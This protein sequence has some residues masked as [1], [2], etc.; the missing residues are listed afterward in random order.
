MSSSTMSKPILAINGG[1]KAFPGPRGRMQPKIGPEEFLSVAERFG[2]PPEAIEKIRAV[3][4][5]VDWGRGPT[6]SRYA[7]AHPRPSKGEVLE[8]AA[9][10]IFG[11]RYVLPVSSGTGALHSAFVAV[12]VGP[13]AEVIV[14]A[15]GFFATAS[16]VVMAR[17]VPV[18]CDVD[19]SLHI[20]PAK[21]EEKITPRTV[22]IAPTCVMGGV[23]DLE[24]ILQIARRHGLKVVEDCA[25]SPGAKYKGRY[26]GAWGDIGCFSI[27]AYKVV[28]GGEGGLVVTNDQRLYERA[29]QL[30]EAGGLWRPD[31]FAPPRYPG[32]LFCGTNYRMSELEAAV[33]VIQLRKMPGLVERYNW[34]QRMILG[35]LKTYREVQPVR[36]NDPEG[37]VG[38]NIRFFTSS[39]ELGRKI[40]A[41]LNAEGIGCG[42]FLWPAECAI[43]GPDAPPDWH[44]YRYMFPLILQGA[45]TETLCPFEC[46]VY[47]ERGGQINYRP[48]D[49][50]TAADLFDRNIMIW[51]ESWYNDED[52]QA[53]AAGI[54]KVLDAY[55][56][57][58]PSA[59]GW[60]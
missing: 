37:G 60:V 8:Q 18:F 15:I 32:E 1:P 9:K 58:D 27:S 53:I 24:P 38:Y 4:C 55:C 23:P 12:G 45:P 46:P 11:V 41:A 54:N 2:L 14:P 21:L 35:R 33:N 28:G 29:C 25:Q 7:T 13:G 59:P 26:V 6:L 51:L 52:C 34:V 49:C 57:E 17:G 39:V 5:A 48:D 40:A 30:A 20:D 22:A 47:R 10:E 43:R 36:R 3:V 19:E 31:R 16:A 42:Q 44:V 56:T 50:P